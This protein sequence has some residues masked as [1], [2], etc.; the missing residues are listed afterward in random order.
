MTKLKPNE[1]ELVGK[2][3]VVNGAV[4]GDDTCKRIE[5][6]IACPLQQV[7]STDAGWTKLF[8]DKA[9]GRYWELTYPNSDWHGGGPPMLT[10]VTEE[11]A[12]SKYGV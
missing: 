2:W 11:F 1:V 10:C 12:R 4:D 9:D 5:E 3:I 6:L 7:G 8:I